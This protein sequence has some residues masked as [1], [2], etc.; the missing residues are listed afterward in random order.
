MLTSDEHSLT[1]FS[2]GLHS[3]SLTLCLF[4]NHWKISIVFLQSRMAFIGI[5][6][7]VSRFNIHVYH[8]K[9]SMLYTHF[10]YRCSNF[11]KLDS[12]RKSYTVIEKKGVFSLVFSL[13]QP[14]TRKKRVENP[15]YTSRV[16]LISTN[17]LLFPMCGS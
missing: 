8:I 17:H 9:C 3:R 7:D 11:I 10:N 15:F 5:S 1:T 12:M 2:F 16:V 6:I 13:S 4:E 14:G